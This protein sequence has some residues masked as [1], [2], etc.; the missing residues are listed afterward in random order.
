MANFDFPSSPSNGQSYSANGITYTYNGTVWKRETGAVKGEKGAPSTVAGDKG[1]K[2]EV[3]QKGDIGAGAPVGQIVS[4]SGSASSLPSGYFLCDG[5]A[6]S[7]TTYAALYAIVGTTHGAG[8][9]SS[10]FN[11][12]DLRDKF[13]V[14]A[15]N[16]TGDTSY[17][18]VSPGATGGSADAVVVEHRHLPQ[19]LNNMTSTE[20]GGNT[21]AVN[22]TLVGNYGAGSGS[23][24]GPLGNRHFMQNEGVPGTNKNLPPYYALAYIIHYAQGG[25][26]AKGQKGEIGGAGFKKVRTAVNTGTLSGNYNSYTNVLNIPS[27]TPN[28][29]NS[30]FLITIT[31]GNFYRSSGSGTATGVMRVNDNGTQVDGVDHTKNTNQHAGSQTFSII[32][33]RG[34]T[35]AR[36]YGIQLARGNNNGVAS[37]TYASIMCIEM[38]PT[39]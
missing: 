1:Q 16:S 24:L 23:G 22:N 18:G 10:T 20:A 15:S 8:D 3:G 25:D 4:W 33:T 5:S 13:V 17:P 26:A 35:G 2:G 11:L 27:F 6:V 29:T 28:S 36:N 21:L 31:I 19:T 34:G 12:P 39:A 9:G 32:D 14:G 37:I 30:V 7:R 38:D